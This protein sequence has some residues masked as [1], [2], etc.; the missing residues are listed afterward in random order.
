MRT[1]MAP[2]RQ[3]VIGLGVALLLASGPQV[4]RGNVLAADTAGARSGAAALS[5]NLVSMPSG[6]F[7]IDGAAGAA[8]LSPV[9]ISGAPASGAGL[10]P[11]FDPV[12]L[13]LGS[14]GIGITNGGGMTAPALAAFNRAAAQWQARIAD[15]ITVNITAIMTNMGS[16]TIIGSTSNVVLQADY[17]TI[18]DQVVA[19]AADEADDAIV[20]FMP[21]AGQFSVYLPP[22]FGLTGNISVSKADLKALGFTGLDGSFGVSDG[23]ITFNTGFSFDFDNSDGV[24]PGTIDFETVTAHE[25]GHILGF[26]S[27]EDNID[28][29]LHLLQVGNVNIDVLDLFRF[30]NNLAGSDPATAADF[31]TFD[32]SLVPG[33]DEITDQVLAWGPLGTTEFRMSTGFWTGDGRQASHWKDNELTGTLIGNLDPTLAYATIV[34]ITEAD[35][36]A[37]DLIGYEILPIP[38]PTSLLL[39]AGGLA[40]LRCRRRR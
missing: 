15:P 26:V 29:M 2:I 7:G 39:L 10:T 9:V 33:T 20:G 3:A 25:I 37:M 12:P 5:V 14:F 6:A 21:T 17:T 40:V 11:V 19:D 35:W 31:T 16:P 32:R 23:T 38:E 18:R 13:Q 27:A 1:E 24:T 4:L 22:N 34:P 8:A 36:R 30:A 28:T